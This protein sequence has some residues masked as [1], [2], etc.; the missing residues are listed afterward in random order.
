MISIFICQWFNLSFI[1][2]ISN[3]KF[4]RT[5]LWFIPIDGKY[6]DFGHDWYIDTG[7]IIVRGL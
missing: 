3:A 7:L 4:A 2:I 1:V 6:T 5:I